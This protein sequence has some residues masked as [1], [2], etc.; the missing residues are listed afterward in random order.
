M[1][2]NLPLER[3][4]LLGS[5]SLFGV[6]WSCATGRVGRSQLAFCRDAAVKRMAI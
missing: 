1:P 6:C 2:L 3:T 4:R 5:S